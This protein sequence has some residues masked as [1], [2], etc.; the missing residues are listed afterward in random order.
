MTSA[1]LKDEQHTDAQAG[2]AAAL[3]LDEHALRVLYLELFGRPPYDT[4]REHWLGRS[5]PELLDEHIGSPE[6]WRHWYEEQLYYFLLV[7]NFRPETDA[8]KELPAKLA[9]GEFDVRTVLHR[10]ALSSSFDLRN[11]G[12]DTFVT[13]VLEQLV[14]LTVQKHEGV[15]AGGKGAY[16]GRSST[17]LGSSAVSQSDVVRIAIES[18]D[19]MRHLATREFER[20]FRTPPERRVL[21]RWAR[22]L[23]LE[24]KAYAAIVRSWLLSEAFSERLASTA[25]KSNQL[26]VRSLFVD[27]IGRLPSDAEALPMRDALDGLSDSRPLRSVMVRLL[28]DSKDV[29]LP[30][31]EDIEDRTLWLAGLFPRFYGRAA[32]KQELEAFATAFNEPDCR[33]ETVLYALLTAPEYHRY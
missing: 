30:K 21:A 17:F 13:V 8:L 24:P 26:F 27:L 19:A 5:L 14:G 16:Q 9:Q 2:D 3:K 1:H 20:L 22:E 6:F 4:E 23:F 10:I 7:D 25:P 32:N 28:V 31:K 33:P 15:L 11:P 12:A 29:R 18:K